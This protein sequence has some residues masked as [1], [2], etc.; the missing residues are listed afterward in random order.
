MLEAYSLNQSFTPTIA[1]PLN[2]ISIE[3]GCTAILTA[4]ATIELNK[5]GI[6]MVSMD[7]ATDAAATEGTGTI[8]MTKNGVAQ[9][10]AQATSTLPAPLSF[11]TL[12][13]VP[14]NNTPCCITSPTTL[15]FIYTGT[16]TTGSINV[17]V[18]KIC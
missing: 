10:Q 3:K 18:T 15:Q 1:I 17:C 8:Q 4:P 11:V 16:E 9:P 14:S 13:Q 2:N 12:V 7:A 6:Y 5:A